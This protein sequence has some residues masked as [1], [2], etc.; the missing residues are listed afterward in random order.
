MSL[1]AIVLTVFRE[2]A[3]TLSLSAIQGPTEPDGI[4]TPVNW[5]TIQ[6]MFYI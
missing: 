3:F 5:N 2:I 4:D 1:V 6:L